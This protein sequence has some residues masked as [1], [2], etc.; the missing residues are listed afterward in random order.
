MTVPLAA[1]LLEYPVA[2]VPGP[3]VDMAHVSLEV[4]E[5]TAVIGTLGVDVMKF[6][7]PQGIEGLSVDMDAILGRYRARGVVPHI[8]K[9]A[10]VVGKLVL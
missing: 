7:C 8:R 3:M 2:Y 4:Y 5:C 10:E 1:L 9:S 6:S